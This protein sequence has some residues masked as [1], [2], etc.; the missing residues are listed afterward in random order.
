MG[1]GGRSG[2]WTL[3]MSRSIRWEAVSKEGARTQTTMSNN[4]LATVSRHSRG[5]E[6]W[7]S[8]HVEAVNM[9]DTLCIKS[10]EGDV[11]I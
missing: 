2:C 11:L 1:F 10:L 9:R 6:L 5:V 7:I 3:I 4:S 8:P